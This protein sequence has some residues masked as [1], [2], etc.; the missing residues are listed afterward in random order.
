M[1]FFPLEAMSNLI[2]EPFSRL[3][4]IQAAANQLGTEIG[5][6]Y[7]IHWYQILIVLIWTAIFVYSSLILLKKRDL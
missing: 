4:A 5:K 7:S 3:N 2:I 6:D 1:Q